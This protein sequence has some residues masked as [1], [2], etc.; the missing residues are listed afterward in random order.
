VTFDS[1]KSKAAAENTYNP[2]SACSISENREYDE[3][4]DAYVTRLLLLVTA[5]NLL[6]LQ[7]A[8]NA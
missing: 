1:Q 4:T 5:T 7:T 6:L 3:A 8:I 2:G